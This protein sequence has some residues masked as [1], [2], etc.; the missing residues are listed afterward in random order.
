MNIKINLELY[1][2]VQICNKKSIIIEL[3]GCS[4]EKCVDLESGFRID[5]LGLVCSLNARVNVET[6]SIATS[7]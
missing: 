2:T 3:C 5:K 6:G 7:G 4:I 1:S